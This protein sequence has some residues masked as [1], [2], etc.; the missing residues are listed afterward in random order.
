MCERWLEASRDGILCGCECKLVKVQAGLDVVFEFLKALHESGVNATAQ[1]KLDTADFAHINSH[2]Q[3][4]T[5][6]SG[7][8]LW[9]QRRLDS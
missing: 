1:F 7:P 5:S 6:D 8:A 3:G 4:L 2:H 9:R